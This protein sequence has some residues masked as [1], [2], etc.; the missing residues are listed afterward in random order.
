MHTAV[1]MSLGSKRALQHQRTGNP[2]LKN[3]QYSKSKRCILKV[4]MPHFIHIQVK[5][6]DSIV[7]YNGRVLRTLLLNSNDQGF[8]LQQPPSNSGETDADQK[9][10]MPQKTS[11]L[12]LAAITSIQR[13]RNRQC[14]LFSFFCDVV[15][16]PLL[17]YNNTGT[18]C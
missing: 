18:T 15:S 12:Q 14:D 16:A 2:K 17:V 6:T 9:P 8:S 7:Q 10:P 4:C 13:Q 5:R 3:W 11:R 1:K